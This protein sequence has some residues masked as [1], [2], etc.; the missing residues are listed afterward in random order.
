MKTDYIQQDNTHPTGRVDIE[1]T[2][3]GG[4]RFHIAKESAWDHLAWTDTLANLAGKCDAVAFG[5][6]AQRHADSRATIQRFVEHTTHAIK[7]FDVNLRSSDGRDFF[8]ADTITAG[9]K[10]ADYVKLNDEELETVCRLTDTK[11]A[12]DLRTTYDLRAIIYTR[13][14]DGTAAY[15]Q[16]GFIE[17]DPVQYPRQDSADTVGAGDA[18]SAGLLSSSRA[19]QKT[20]RTALDIAN[21]LGAF[22]ASRAGATPALPTDML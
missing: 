15:T 14:K 7:L 13:G 18:C 3:D 5:S 8:D 2:G 19:W 21:K 1:R 6:L 9:C 4:H 10:L 22:V 20:S 12:Q 11:D 16:E 17:G